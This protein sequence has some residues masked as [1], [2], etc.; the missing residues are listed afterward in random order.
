M[1]RGKSAAKILGVLA[2]LAI[3]TGTVFDF[4]AQLKKVLYNEAFRTL[5]ESSEHYNQ[6]FISRIDSHITTLHVISGSLAQIDNPTREKMSL[7]LQSA[8]D[9]SGFKRISF[10]DSNGTSFSNDSEVIDVSERDYFQ[11][12]LKGETVVSEPLKSALDGAGIIVISVPVYH[13][14]KVDGVLYGSYSLSVAGNK[15]LDSSYYGDGYGF[16][17]SKNGDIVLSSDHADKL[18]NE[19]NLLSFLDKTDFVDYSPTELREDM[20]AGKRGAFAFIFE[21]E[22]R[23]VSFMPSKVNDWYTFSFASDMLASRQEA[24][25]N[26]IV[27]ELIL[28]LLSAGILL[29]ILFAV[30]SRRHNRE[31]LAAK[32]QYQSLISNINGGVLVTAYAT[33]P[34]KIV[35][36][37]TSD[38]FTQMT[39]Y[40]SEDI[41][42]LFQGQYILIIHEEDRQRAFSEYRKQTE[43]GTTYRMSYRIITKSGSEIWVMDTGYAVQDE[44]GKMLNHSVLTDITVMKRQEEELRL[45]D[46]R[47]RIA[48][49]ASNAAVFEADLQNRAYLYFENTEPLLGSTPQNLLKQTECLAGMSIEEYGSAVKGIFFHPDDV[50]VLSEALEKAFR[51]ESV[52]F[53]ARIKKADGGYIW[54]KIDVG[55]ISDKNGNPMRAVGYMTDISSIKHNTELLEI[56]VQTDT[57]T[58]LYNK[59]ATAALTNELIESESE[60]L[61]ALI[62]LDVDNFKGVNDTLGHAF[63]DAV[64]LD[65]CAKLKALFRSDDIVGRVGGDEFAVVMKNV[66]NVSGVLRKAAEIAGA[67][68]QTFI[69]EKGDYKISCSMGIIMIE[70]KND[71]YETLFPKADA[72]LYQAKKKGKDLFVLY[73][74]EDAANYPIERIR[75]NDTEP[76]TGNRPWNIEE[77]ILELMYTSKD[78]SGSINMAL[79]MIGQ[80]YHLSRACVFENDEDNIGTCNTFEW[81]NSGIEPQI[82][83]LGNVKLADG[84]ES[85]LSCF[86]DKG[87]FYCN[88]VRTLQPYVRGLM[89]SQGILSTLQMTIVNDNKVGGFIGFDECSE[90]RAWTADE[91]DSI[92]FL[93]KILSIFLLKRRAESALKKNLVN[94]IEIL[95]SLP[96]CICVINPE[97]HSIEYA[98][99]KMLEI[100]PSAHGGALCYRTLRGGQNAPCKNCLVE[101]IKRGDTK[102]L[103]IV[104]E[105][106]SLRLNVNALF[107]NWSKN[108]KMVLIYETDL[109][110]GSGER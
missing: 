64:L 69:G 47:F 102:N 101:Q 40:T 91:I 30:D 4:S 13:N 79:S 62:V 44:N 10:A 104:S 37:Y 106:K 58:G 50:R 23:F 56:Q 107:I 81:C 48:I 105:D 86:D 98:N 80:Q 61:H 20:R 8:V 67:F 38:G 108:K 78:F 24:N 74:E 63:G 35:P 103:E 3:V 39:G 43:T 33:E 18:C 51:G 57:M 21:G 92:S 110:P 45:V 82:D 25:T 46:E 60:G 87:L 100:L 54:C 70:S 34:E 16:V 72:A 41:N 71:R 29:L 2:I 12:A 26:G 83:K 84:N 66:P 77:R 55:V 17:L 90:Y 14:G 28:K 88:D 109:I 42:Q 94:R 93:A 53:E 89:E 5:T 31:I 19:K 75:V 85:I 27:L 65:V 15:L 11:R 1:N 52:N 68:R 36:E 22:R 73:R 32:Q 59:V 97:T 96:T 49:K 99:S 95:D 7:L 76:Q 9:N 6:A